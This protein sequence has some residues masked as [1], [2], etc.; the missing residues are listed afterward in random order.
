METQ[1]LIN[2]QWKPSQNEQN[3]PRYLWKFFTHPDKLFSI[4]HWLSQIKNNQIWILNIL[5][6]KRIKICSTHNCVFQD[7]KITKG[8]DH[9]QI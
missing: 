3:A 2:K 9:A 8:T 4:R 1:K 5:L 7:Y 6:H